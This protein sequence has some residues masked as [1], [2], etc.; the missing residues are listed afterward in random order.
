M[1]CS[2]RPRFTTTLVLLALLSA[3]H[4]AT[5]TAADEHGPPLEENW[6]GAEVEPPV[7]RSPDP[8]ILP[9]GCLDH[10]PSK[11]PDHAL[12]LK[13]EGARWGSRPDRPQLTTGEPLRLT[14][15]SNATIDTPITARY[16]L[17]R[18]DGTTLRVELP[19]Q[20]A[21]V[22][23]MGCDPYPGAPPDVCDNAC[24]AERHPVEVAPFAAAAFEQAGAYR[25]AIEADHDAFDPASLILEV[26]P[27]P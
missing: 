17:Q 1:A 25:L 14:L 10:P 2:A 15:E 9:D 6:S 18:P 23:C 22:R 12:T 11:N 3:C 16:C 4:G 20:N 24:I 13:L 21:T 7:Q 27:P 5:T 19:F 8:P 26:A